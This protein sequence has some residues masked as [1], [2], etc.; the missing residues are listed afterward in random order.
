[1]RLVSYAPRTFDPQFGWVIKEGITTRWALEG[2]ATGHF[3]PHGIRGRRV[4]ARDTR[5]VLVTGD[6][7]TEALH[8]DDEETFVAVAERAL[9]AGGQPL[10]LVNVAQAGQRLPRYVE[11]APVQ[12]RIFSPRWTVVVLGEDDLADDSWVQ[13]ATHFRGGREGQPLRLVTMPLSGAG[14]RLRGRVRRWRAQSA[15]LQRLERQLRSM[16]DEAANTPFFR[17][18]E[19]PPGERSFRQAVA[20]PVR[21]ELEL[22]AAAYQNRVTVLFLV[23]FDGSTSPPPTPYEREV[24][25]ACAARQLSCLSVREAWAELAGRGGTPYGFPNTCWNCGHLNE[26]GH[27]LVGELLARELLRL[28]ARGLL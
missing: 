23:P 17:Q 4:P 26:E 5:P 3:G 24:L 28:R 22:L 11:Q 25:A 2:N 13:N 21:A 10:G 12:E 1:M 8:V 27:R 19:G 20:F 7:F 18:P 15:L 14:G 16:V 6:S 9:Q